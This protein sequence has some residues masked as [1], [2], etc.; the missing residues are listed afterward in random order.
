MIDF[1][2]IKLF[3]VYDLLCA[4]DFNPNER[5]GDVFSYGN[6]KAVLPEQL[7]RCI[8]KYYQYRAAIVKGETP[9]PIKSGGH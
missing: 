2:G 8:L 7:R 9:P 6:P 4:K 3:K 1:L 5:T